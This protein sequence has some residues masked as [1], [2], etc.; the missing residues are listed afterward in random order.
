MRS[1]IGK[2]TGFFNRLQ[3]GDED[4]V[5]LTLAAVADRPDRCDVDLDHDDEQFAGRILTQ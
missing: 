3:Q 2:A 5:E 4:K 1:G